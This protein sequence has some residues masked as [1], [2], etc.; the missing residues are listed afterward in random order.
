MRPY[1]VS[2]PIMSLAFHPTRDTLAIG[3]IDGTLELVSFNNDALQN[4]SIL[5]PK[6]E[7]EPSDKDGNKGPF[8]ACWTKVAMHEGSVR[9]MVFTEDGKGNLNAINFE[10][11]A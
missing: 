4:Y 11:F 3:L 6:S 1:H 8:S 10:V 7:A 2:N 5:S 9:S